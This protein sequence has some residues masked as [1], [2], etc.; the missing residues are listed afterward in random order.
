M[1]I[2]FELYRIF[3][4]VAN[5]QNI[6]KA[7]QELMI[8]QPAVTKSIKNLEEQLGGTLFVRTKKGVTL[9][10]EGKELYKY[11]KQAIEFINNGEHQFSSLK[12]LEIGSIRIGVSTT[13]TKTF[14]L[15]YLEKFHQSYPK[16]DIQIFTYLT[17]DLVEMMRNGS[18][19]IIILNLPFNDTKQELNIIPC[20]EVQDCFI[21]SE[22]YKFLAQKKIPLAE[23]N[24]YPLIL[25]APKSNTRIFL[26]TFCLKH[27]VI[28]KP[29]I[30]IASYSLV[31]EFAKIGLG[32]G[33]ATK[34]YIKKELA[35]K[36]LYELKTIPSLPKRQIG[37][38]YSKHT[39]PNFSTQKLIEIIKQDKF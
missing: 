8:S 3:Y 5:N 24:N 14:L 32:I 31:V 17:S 30:N 4:V 39:I 12:N 37:I 23:L 25:Q 6:T 29:N 36:E 33:Y 38:A 2:D 7:S 35:N 18:I 13:L 16:I 22:H 11:I 28:L 26:D 21:V 15:P 19:D 1:N 20:K 10:P 34:N 27:K 9:T